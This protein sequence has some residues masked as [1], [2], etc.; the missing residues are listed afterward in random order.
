MG[1]HK[2]LTYYIVLLIVGI[3]QMCKIL[4]ENTILLCMYKAFGV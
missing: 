4:V 3:I 1:L 2:T